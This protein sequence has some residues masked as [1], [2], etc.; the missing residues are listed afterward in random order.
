[1][2]MPERRELSIN[3]VKTSHYLTRSQDFEPNGR[4]GELQGPDKGGGSAATEA[5]YNIEGKDR[6]TQG[7]SEHKETGKKKRRKESPLTPTGRRG[8]SFGGG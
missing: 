2:R 8:C 4:P 3:A 7:D 6:A 1:M 5:T